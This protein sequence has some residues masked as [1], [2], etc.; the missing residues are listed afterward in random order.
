MSQGSKSAHYQA[1]KAAGVKLERH[2][3][4]YTT[5]ELA[6]LCE[7]AGV[8]VEVPEPAVRNAPPPK[9]D[10]IA[11]IKQQIAGLGS[12]I[13]QLASI[14]ASTPAPAPAPTREPE[15]AKP[16]RQAHR[17]EPIP[18]KPTQPDPHEH[19]GVTLNTHAEDEPIRKDEHGNLWYQNEVNKPGYPKPRG[20]RVLRDM[21]PGTV[22][23]TIKVAGGYTETFEIP[24]DPTHA[25]PM[26]VKVTLPSYQTGIY[27]APGMP[28]KIHTYQGARGFDWDDVNRFYGGADLVPSSIKRTYVSSDLCYDMTTTIRAIEDEYRE[29]VLKKESIR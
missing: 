22:T 7:A 13:S 5:D 12:M 8:E 4:E 2:Y 6:Q 19:A 20:R 10:E 17:N 9:N 3:R 23:E 14:V 28:F 29:R 16:T 1:L 18:Q 27:K 24:G 15:P 26:E 11:E 25:K 21:N